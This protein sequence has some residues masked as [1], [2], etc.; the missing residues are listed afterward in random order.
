MGWCK[1]KS[2][3]CAPVWNQEARQCPE[4]CSGALPVC[5]LGHDTSPMSGQTMQS[6]VSCKCGQHPLCL[7]VG[8]CH[9]HP[10]AL[11]RPCTCSLK[12]A[13]ILLDKDYRAKVADVGLS[14]TLTQYHN[15]SLSTYMATSDIGTFSWSAP[16]VL[17]GLPCTPKADVYSFGVVRPS[18]PM[19][20]ASAA[21]SR[22]G[23]RWGAAEAL[24]L[25]VPLSAGPDLHP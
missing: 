20:L 21:V 15:D 23:R 7:G 5:L 13:N 4:D 10:R 8:P 2:S 6:T 17:L 16:E 11:T 19:L 25:Y 3:A 22:R 24:V 14:K 1:G 18:C 12:S 9:W